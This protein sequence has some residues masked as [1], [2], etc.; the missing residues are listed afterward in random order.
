MKHIILILNAALLAAPLARAAPRDVSAEIAAR[1]AT[2][3]SAELA[4][5]PRHYEQRNDLSEQ[6]IERQGCRYALRGRADIDSL[7]DLIAAAGLA[8]PTTPDVDPYVGQILIRLHEGER[9]HTI[10][11]D[12]DY[13][14]ARARGQYRIAER[15]TTSAAEIEAATSTERDLR[16]WAS[17]HRS[18]ATGRCAE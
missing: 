2:I 4:L 15:G 6:D 17:Q 16:F 5:L 18:L 10:V 11:L 12:K 13:D 7:V 14:N 9:D 1:R 3:E 8:T